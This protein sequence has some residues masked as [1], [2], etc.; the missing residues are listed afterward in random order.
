MTSGAGGGG[1]AAVSAGAASTGGG[2]SAR[3]AS[4]AV[5]TGSG[6]RRGSEVST[7]PVGGG[8]SL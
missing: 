2:V 5:T 8:W 4:G 1:T 7:A 3:G 6:A